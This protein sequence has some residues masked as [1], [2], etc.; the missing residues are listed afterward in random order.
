MPTNPKKYQNGQNRSKTGQKH[1]QKLAKNGRKRS[2]TVK[3]S[4]FQNKRR[5]HVESSSNLNQP[6][7]NETRVKIS[8][9]D[10]RL[11][12]EYVRSDWFGGGVLIFYK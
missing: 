3:N 4:L 12:A 1:G 5:R 11:L 7:P 6:V 8:T 10:R 2:K 9:L